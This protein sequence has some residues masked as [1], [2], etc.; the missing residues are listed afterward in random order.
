MSAVEIAG[1]RVS[2][3]HLDHF[4][5]PKCRTTERRFEQNT[6]PMDVGQIQMCSRLGIWVSISLCC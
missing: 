6:H 5:A 4:L 1:T 3:E 2:E